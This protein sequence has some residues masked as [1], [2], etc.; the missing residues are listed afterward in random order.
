MRE[1]AR[2]LRRLADSMTRHLSPR[3]R[4][5]YLQRASEHLMNVDSGDEM[6]VPEF[7]ELEDLLA[8]AGRGGGGLSPTQWDRLVEIVNPMETT[9]GNI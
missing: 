8:V 3:Q 7:D 5:E 6:P 4:M 1:I 2:E 9:W